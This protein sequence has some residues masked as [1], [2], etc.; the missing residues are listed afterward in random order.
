[1]PSTCSKKKET[2]KNKFLA[3]T[4]ILI[5]DEEKAVMLEKLAGRAQMEGTFYPKSYLEKS[6]L[7]DFF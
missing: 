2:T 5:S 4:L 1:V 3:L 6:Y 7:W